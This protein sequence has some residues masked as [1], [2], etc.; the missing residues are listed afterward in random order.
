MEALRLRHKS[1]RPAGGTGTCVFMREELIRCCRCGESKAPDEFAWRRKA[2]G[3][4]DTHCRPC[5]SAY[6]KEHYAANKQ[7]YID[8]AAERKRR[9]GR[10]RWAYLIDF[11][12][13]NP[14]S[15]CGETDPLVL[16]FD[17][18]EDK[19]FDISQ[20]LISRPWTVVL[21]E[22]AKCDVVCAN[23]HRRRT[24][25]RG[26]FMRAAVAQLVERKPSKLQVAGSR[27][28]RRS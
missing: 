10:E 8:Q 7:R 9:V 12:A 4:R 11:F 22:V 6:G 28:V 19:A 15:D 14:C 18:L 5:R 16:E 20:G 2:Q 25:Q 17:H 24:A 13:A 3:Q 27:P 26:G 1:P 23:C 21:D